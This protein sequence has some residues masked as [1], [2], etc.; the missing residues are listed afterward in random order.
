[1][2]HFDFLHLSFLPKLPESASHG[3]S[4]PQSRSCSSPGCI[5]C[6]AR[7]G[8]QERGA[9]SKYSWSQAACESRGILNWHYCMIM[10]GTVL[11]MWLREFCFM[12]VKAEEPSAKNASQSIEQL[13]QNFLV[14]LHLWRTCIFQI[15]LF[16]FRTVYMTWLLLTHR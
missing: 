10:C 11:E 6:K 16:A 15:S 8:G 2:R 14:I 9:G 7:S 5:V 4:L 1:M 13:W 3:I 12:K